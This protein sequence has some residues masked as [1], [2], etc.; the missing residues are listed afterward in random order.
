MVADATG[1]YKDRPKELPAQKSTPNL[2]S[3]VAK[4]A[5]TQ[6]SDQS[7]GGTIDV[8]GEEPEGRLTGPGV[9]TARTQSQPQMTAEVLGRNLRKH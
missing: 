7:Q 1:R 9:R 4:P 5:Q 2:K 6:P 8:A 3:P